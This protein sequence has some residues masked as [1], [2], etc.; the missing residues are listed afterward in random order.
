M[1]NVKPSQSLPIN[2]VPSVPPYNSYV[3][4]TLGVL[5]GVTGIVGVLLGVAVFVG[6]TE[7]VLVVVLVGVAVLV[8]VG[9]LDGVGVFVA[10]I[11]GNGPSLVKDNTDLNDGATV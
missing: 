5:L 7:G 2:V 3:L 8:G 6:V 10:A 4:Q 1:L 9:E 11:G